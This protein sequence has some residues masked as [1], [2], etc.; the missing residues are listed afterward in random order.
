MDKAIQTAFGNFW[1]GAV[2]EQKKFF[3][4]PAAARVLFTPNCSQRSVRFQRAR[5]RRHATIPSVLA[6]S[7]FGRHGC[8]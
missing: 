3:R 5:F 1:A 8:S 7:G 4:C 2:P 6:H